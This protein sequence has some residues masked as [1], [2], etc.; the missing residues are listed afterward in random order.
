MDVEEFPQIES[1]E[2][3]REIRE[4]A[5]WGYWIW[6]TNKMEVNQK[7]KKETSISETE[8]SIKEYIIN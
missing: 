3:T 6:M 8:S 5:V 4:W 1:V 7:S 2:W